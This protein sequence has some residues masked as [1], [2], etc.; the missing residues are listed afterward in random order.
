M[1]ESA[2]LIHRYSCADALRDGVLIDATPV[3]R[4]AGIRFRA[5]LAPRLG[6]CLSGRP[7]W[8]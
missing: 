6:A 8:P 7:L 2:D 4:E 5:A 1:F 3:A